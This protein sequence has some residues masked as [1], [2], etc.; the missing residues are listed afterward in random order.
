MSSQLRKSDRVTDGGKDD[1]GLTAVAV[2]PDI[3]ACVL[4]DPS[5]N[6]RVQLR[7]VV[8]VARELQQNF[9]LSL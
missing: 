8:G 4:T 2:E 1:Q 5:T 6:E 3:P 7:P 9:P